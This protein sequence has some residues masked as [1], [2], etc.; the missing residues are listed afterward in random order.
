MC[1][2]LALKNSVNFWQRIL[3]GV[4]IMIN[5]ASMLTQEKPPR[6][7]RKLPSRFI[8]VGKTITRYGQTFRCVL[9]EL[10]PDSPP[11]EACR[12]CWFA[13]THRDERLIANCNAIQCS[14]WDRRDGKNVWFVPED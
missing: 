6:V 4:E 1:N 10:S 2:R 8:P 11:N 12:G 14:S 9:R 3:I 13:R 5:F 7:E